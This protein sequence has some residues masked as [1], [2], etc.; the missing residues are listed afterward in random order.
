ME[1]KPK[2]N[3]NK[4]DINWGLQGLIDAY[5]VDNLKI[6]NIVHL[7]LMILRWLMRLHLA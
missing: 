6:R 1:I 2:I 7:E 3:S 4:V 5:D